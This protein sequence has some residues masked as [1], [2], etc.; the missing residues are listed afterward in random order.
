MLIKSSISQ[1]NEDSW[2]RNLLQLN[3]DLMGWRNCS[4][5]SSTIPKLDEI[6]LLNAPIILF[7]NDYSGDRLSYISFV[8]SSS[9]LL[10]DVP[11]ILINEIT[12]PW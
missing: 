4:L 5:I 6:A 2:E 10:R 9:K 12:F 7:Y 11:V 3:F 8:S 1:C